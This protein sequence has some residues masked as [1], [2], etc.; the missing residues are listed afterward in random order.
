MSG[1]TL[2]RNLPSQ[3]STQIMITM[4]E[5]FP[6]H[7]HYHSNEK[8]NPVLK[9]VSPSAKLPRLILEDIF[10]FPPDREILGNNAYLIFS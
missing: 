7:P 9:D 10:A 6:S 3:L 1:L 4:S 5:N 8:T 2:V